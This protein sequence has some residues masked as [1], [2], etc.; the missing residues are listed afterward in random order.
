MKHVSRIIFT[1][2]I[3]YSFACGG[4]KSD[5]TEKSTQKDS[6]ETTEKAAPKAEETEKPKEEVSDRQQ[7]T[8]GTFIEIE[9][10]DYF[11]FKIKP[12]NGDEKS[13]MVL[14]GD[15]TYEKIAA[16][17]NKYKGTKIRVTW[18]AKKQNIPEAGGEIDIEEYIKGEILK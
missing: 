14:K 1:I 12:E 10:G 4:G 3:T 9:Q 18:E 5:K 7:V 13:F 8:V 11:Y 17:P 2:L 6:S 16:N 15:D